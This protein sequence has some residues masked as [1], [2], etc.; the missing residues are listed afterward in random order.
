MYKYEKARLLEALLAVHWHRTTEVNWTMLFTPLEHLTSGKFTVLEAV[1]GQ[2]LMYLHHGKSQWYYNQGN[3]QFFTSWAFPYLNPKRISKD[4]PIILPP[5]FHLWYT[6]IYVH[7]RKVIDLWIWKLFSFATHTTS[8]LLH[9]NSCAVLHTIITWASHHLP[10]VDC[11]IMLPIDCSRPILNLLISSMFW[12]NMKLAL[13]K[14]LH[15]KN[16]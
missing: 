8:K 6:C 13:M 14:L 5:H 2:P 9:L 4:V 15:V 12:F 1:D 16:K 7:H 11:Y 3:L 10:Q